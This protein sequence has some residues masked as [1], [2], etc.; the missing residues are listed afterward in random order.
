MGAT[1]GGDVAFET[2]TSY[3]TPVVSGVAA[4]L[5][6]LQ[7]KLGQLSDPLLVR[8]AILRSAV[9]CKHDTV[10]D[11]RRLLAGRLNVRG[12][13][14]IIMRSGGPRTESQRARGKNIG[15]VVAPPAARFP[16]ST[17]E[18]WP[19]GLDLGQTSAE[20]DPTSPAQDGATPAAGAV[21]GTPTDAAVSPS[22]CACG[23]P[24]KAPAQFAYALGELYFDFGTE[25]RR[26]S[27]LQ[28]MGP[29][30]NPYDPRQLLAYLENNPWDAASVIWTLRLDQTP[31]YAVQPRGSFGSDGYQR[32]RR[33]LGEQVTDGVERISVPGVIGGRTTLF[34]G[35][36]VPVIWPEI[37]GMYSWT[38]NALLKAV[39]SVSP[40]AD[41]VG[42]KEKKDYV[43][44]TQPTRNFLERVYFELRN[45][46]TTPEHRALNFAATNAFSIHKI[47]EAAL[48]DQMELD[49]FGVE[50]SPI[51]RPE[52]DCWDVKLVFFDPR[53]V[54]EQARKVYRAT[55]DV[56]DVVPVTVGPVRSWSI[57]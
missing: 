22:A 38:T 15:P 34:T 13:M 23:C 1:P 42:E 35:E 44:K 21:A 8:D 12:A 2:G 28:Q 37:R 25:A 46:G 57:R 51:C 7:W 18:I 9:G 6:S 54:F 4:L 56:S 20:T 16:F 11:C 30:G 17:S 32:L 43:E 24:G 39:T 45:L 36:T 5:L 48:K 26:D 53:K 3:A 10:T 40:P 33:F 31:I 41:N 27:I 14:S 49:Q 50:R 47:F 55:I 29:G 19:A 52:S